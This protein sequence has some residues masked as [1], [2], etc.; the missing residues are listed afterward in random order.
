MNNYGIGEMISLSVALAVAAIPEGLV[1][2][3][4]VVLTVGMQRILR[5]HGLVRAL[6]QQGGELFVKLSSFTYGAQTG[7][8]KIYGTSD[9]G[10]II[11]SNNPNQVNTSQWNDITQ[12]A[13]SALVTMT[14]SYWKKDL[15]LF[16]PQGGLF[17]AYGQS[18]YP[19]EDSA[20]QAPIPY[21]DRF[22]ADNNAFLYTIVSQAGSSSVANNLYDIRPIISRA[23][24][25]QVETAAGIT[26]SYS[27]ILNKPNH[28][29]L[30]VIQG[31][32]TGEYYHLSSGDYMRVLGLT[33]M[34]G[35]LNT[36]LTQTS[37][38]AENTYVHRYG[39]ERISGAKTFEITGDN[40]F[41]L[42][43]GVNT[44]NIFVAQSG[45]VKIYSI[46]GVKLIDSAS[47][48]LSDFNGK[49]SFDWN[50]R[51]GFDSSLVNS[52]DWQNRMT[53]DASNVASIDWNVRGL[54]E[55][56]STVAVDWLGH[57]LS[58]NWSTNS[59]LRTSGTVVN[60]FRL[61]GVSGNL[62]TRLRTSGAALTTYI[63]SVGTSISGDVTQ[64]GITLGAQINSLSGYANNRFVQTGSI[65]AYLTGV[66]TGSDTMYY[67]YQTYV[68]PTVPY[69]VANMETT[70]TNAFYQF[71]ISGRSTSGFFAVY[72]DTI[73]ETGLFLNV[74]VK[75]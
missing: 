38:Y 16:S 22:L 31:G 50:L 47:A 11:D 33:G 68:F 15:V 53:Y 30:P 19:D 73:L 72:S 69:V 40:Y 59:V 10:I 4:T 55:N 75:S 71:L 45:Y 42:S 24:G 2:G 26:I 1:I 62:E 65:L 6:N 17:Y 14:P 37:G 56:G 70:N 28:N 8:L 43:T 60:Y 27:Q 64:T 52:I 51:A 44:G 23:F 67:S 41:A 39:T 35:Q 7:F 63:N 58:G 46:D 54:Y 36:K 3:L 5:R 13:V 20:K 66:G 18:E 21:A 48:S 25:S 74:L 61:T 12:P 9:V 49:G 57:T 34:S 32:T 29:D